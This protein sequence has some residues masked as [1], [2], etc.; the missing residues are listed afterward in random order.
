MV[1]NASGRAS[2]VMRAALKR[3]QPAAHL[4]RFGRHVDFAAARSHGWPSLKGLQNAQ[5]RR[6]AQPVLAR[7]DRHRRRL[8]RR[9][10]KPVD[11]VCL[12]PVSQRCPGHRLSSFVITKHRTCPSRRPAVPDARI[13]YSALAGRSLRC[14][15]HRL[16]CFFAWTLRSLKPFGQPMNT[17][18]P[19]VPLIRQQVP[20]V[21]RSA[22][23]DRRRPTAAAS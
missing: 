21:L 17:A 1:P 19:I 20:E 5:S 3:L 16:F 10:A 6:R 12:E 14:S 22:R 11:R 4:A 13:A 2:I 9:D 23:D 7:V 15:T 8:C 18:C